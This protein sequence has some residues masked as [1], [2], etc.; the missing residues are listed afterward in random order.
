MTRS[1]SKLRGLSV[2]GWVAAAACSLESGGTTPAPVAGAGIRFES[3]Q[4]ERAVAVD[5]SLVPVV[6]ACGPG[7]YVRRTAEGWI[8]AAAT[9]S[10]GVPWSAI[11][12]FD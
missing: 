10:S 3:G 8:C 4:G 6:S 1:G 7:E 2:L 11:C 12:V 5:P 9:S